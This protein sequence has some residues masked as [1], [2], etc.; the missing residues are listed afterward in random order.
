[1]KQLGTNAK[2]QNIRSRDMTAALFPTAHPLT[3]EA[4]MALAEDLSLELDMMQI[5]THPTL[6]WAP[7]VHPLINAAHM[8]LGKLRQKR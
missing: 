1:L 8:T 2:C 4:G 5:A 3:S 6:T 7:T